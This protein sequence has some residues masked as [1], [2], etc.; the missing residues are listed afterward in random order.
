MTSWYHSRKEYYQAKKLIAACVNYMMSLVSGIV[1]HLVWFGKYKNTWVLPN[2]N[3]N[4]WNYTEIPEASTVLPFL[5]HSMKP[6][7]KRK[8]SY[9]HMNK[10]QHNL[11]LPMIRILYGTTKIETSSPTSRLVV[12]QGNVQK[13]IFSYVG[14]HKM[15]RGWLATNNN[16][17]LKEYGRRSIGERAGAKAA[18]ERSSRYTGDQREGRLEKNA[19]QQV[20]KDHENIKELCRSMVTTTWKRE[21]NDS[22]NVENSP[23]SIVPNTNNKRSEAK[24]QEEETCTKQIIPSQQTVKPSNWATV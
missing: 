16:E 4:H 3:G 5:M 22:S 13:E 8:D 20:I 18:E 21:G 19:V 12:E 11:N 7:K 10:P 2:N 14:R 9:P 17:H 6:V 1:L 24:Q 15:L 23:D